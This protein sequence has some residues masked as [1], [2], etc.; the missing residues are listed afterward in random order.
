MYKPDKQTNFYDRYLNNVIT[1][2]IT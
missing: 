2:K 1:K